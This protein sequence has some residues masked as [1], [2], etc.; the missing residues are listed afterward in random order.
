MTVR[1]PYCQSSRVMTKDSARKAGCTIGAIAGAAGGAAGAA[2]GAE[3]GVTAGLIVG[4]LGSLFGGMAGAIVGALVGGAVCGGSG[5][6]FGEIIDAKILDNF[7][8]LNCD[9]RF[10]T[11]DTEGTDQPFHGS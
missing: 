11:T 10:G 3:I 6:A 5:A 2:G 4:P 7:V 1:C 9:Y 8:C